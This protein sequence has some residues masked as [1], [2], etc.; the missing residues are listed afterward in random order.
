LKQWK[1]AEQFFLEQKSAWNPQAVRLGEG[2][3]LMFFVS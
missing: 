1:K 3:G 2:F